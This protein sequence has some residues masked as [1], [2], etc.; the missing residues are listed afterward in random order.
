MKTT[1]DL[2]RLS[3]K[4][5]KS[6]ETINNQFQKHAYHAMKPNRLIIRSTQCYVKDMHV[7]TGQYST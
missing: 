3:E 5:S 4:C 2:S 1:H 6:L 7:S